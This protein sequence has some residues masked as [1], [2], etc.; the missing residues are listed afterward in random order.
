LI[1]PVDYF[2]DLNFIFV[3]KCFEG[4]YKSSKGSSLFAWLLTIFFFTE[5]VGTV[6]NIIKH[7]KNGINAIPLSGIFLALFNKVILRDLKN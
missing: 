5:V 1:V 7:K 2:K 4:G 3:K 6:Y